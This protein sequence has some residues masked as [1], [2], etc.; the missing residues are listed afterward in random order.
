MSKRAAI[1]ALIEQRVFAERI[2]TEAADSDY[3]GRLRLWAADCATRSLHL[4]KGEALAW[5][6]AALAI[7]AA[8]HL[9]TTGE[10]QYIHCDYPALLAAAR[11]SA[12]SSVTEAKLAAA[13][14]AFDNVF[15][16]AL[17]AATHSRR[18]IRNANKRPQQGQ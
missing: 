16:G 2:L 1:V 3:Q 10:A 6:S 17:A 11:R 7:D 14:A 8:R 15:V 18:A 13:L 4:L 5:N 12:F 9:A